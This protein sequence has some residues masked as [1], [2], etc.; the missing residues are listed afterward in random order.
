MISNTVLPVGVDLFLA[1]IL[2]ADIH[3]EVLQQL[4]S[5]VV[6]HLLLTVIHGGD[7][8]DDS[9]VTTGLDGDCHN[10]DLKSEYL[11]VLVIHAH[12]V[13]DLLR[14]PQ[15]EVD[16]DVDL[17]RDLYRADTEDTA[18]VDDADATDACCTNTLSIARMV[19]LPS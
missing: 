15:L 2:G 5:T 12:T 11:H 17:L 14:V 9:E 8:D 10:G 4:L 13:I 6:A 18:S 3:A 16:D 1:D 19:K 7:L